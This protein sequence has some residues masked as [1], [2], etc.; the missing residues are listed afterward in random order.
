MIREAK[1]LLTDVLVTHCGVKERLIA[2]S[3]YEQMRLESRKEYPFAALV[4]VTGRYD[5][6]SRTQIVIDTE[7]GRTYV[8]ARTMR[9]L[10][11][12]VVLEHKNEEAADELFSRFIGNLPFNFEI[13][14]VNGT[15]NPTAEE[16]SDFMSSLLERYMSAVLIEF[17]IEA[18]PA[19]QKAY[20]IEDITP[21]GEFKDDQ[22]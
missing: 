6:P 8:Q 19:A 9:I 21:E 7:E 22:K 20:R 13:N 10:P 4:S 16:H 3:G 15:I 11:I 5:E 17:A 1:D 12:R 2:R 14:K 18:Y